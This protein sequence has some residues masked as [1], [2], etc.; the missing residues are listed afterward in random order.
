MPWSLLA[1]LQSPRAPILH[2]VRGAGKQHLR[3]APS[4]QIISL[5]RNLELKA[6][7][8]DLALMSVHSYAGLKK[9]FA[10]S[11]VD[12][13]LAQASCPLLAVPF[14]PAL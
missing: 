9:L 2:E 13:V 12:A 5:M 10:P 14:P 4:S 8:A 6:R 11:M 3:P 7:C 1:P